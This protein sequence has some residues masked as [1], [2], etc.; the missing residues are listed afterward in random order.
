MG[1]NNVVIGSCNTVPIFLVRRCL[2]LE[3]EVVET[4]ASQGRPES[5]FA[6]LSNVVV[7]VVDVDVEFFLFLAKQLVNSVVL[8]GIRYKTFTR[9][10]LISRLKIGI[11]LKAE[12]RAP[13][14]IESPES[15][16]REI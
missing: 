14:T 10:V 7:V 11:G 8:H 12:K 2:Q 5:P 9:F 15:R 3:F 6:F 16:E 13:A 1:T 4:C